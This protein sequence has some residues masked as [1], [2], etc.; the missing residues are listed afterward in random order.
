MPD[1]NNPKPN[2]EDVQ[3]QMRAAVERIR[4]TFNLMLNQEPDSEENEKASGASAGT[5][6]KS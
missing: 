4:K 6:S 2:P 1:E 3:V 5:D